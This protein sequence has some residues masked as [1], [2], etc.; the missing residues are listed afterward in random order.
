MQKKMEAIVIDVYDQDGE[1]LNSMLMAADWNEVKE[2]MQDIIDED[3]LPVVRRAGYIRFEADGSLS[4]EAEKT[5]MTQEPVRIGASCEPV[6]LKLEMKI[7][8]C[9]MN[10]CGIGYDVLKA[11]ERFLAQGSATVKDD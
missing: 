5:G 8:S 6:P 10:C 11:Q 1:K 4:V 7:G 9:S 3:G 2:K